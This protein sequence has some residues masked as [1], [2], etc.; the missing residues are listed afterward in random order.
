MEDLKLNDNDFRELR[1]LLRIAIET[2]NDKIRN[3][4]VKSLDFLQ[5]QRELYSR[6]LDK[7]V[8]I[9]LG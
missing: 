8:L 6:L 5:N 1:I 3:S 4:S 9:S 7:I 2:I